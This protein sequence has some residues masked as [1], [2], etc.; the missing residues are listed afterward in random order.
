MKFFKQLII[1]VVASCV[2]AVGT[3]GV[4]P[5]KNDNKPPPPKEGKEVPKPPKENPPPR[6]NGNKG[7]DNKRGKP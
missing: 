5:Q 4:E 6:D 7:N 3:L 2:L 1:A